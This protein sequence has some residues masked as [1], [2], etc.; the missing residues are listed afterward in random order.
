MTAHSEFMGTCY[1]NQCFAHRRRG[2]HPAGRLAEPAAER[3]VHRPEESPSSVD[4]EPEPQSHLADTQQGVRGPGH[5]GDSDAVR[6]QNQRHR[7]GSV[8]GIGK[9]RVFRPTNLTRYSCY[10]F[11]FVHA[12]AQEIETLESGRK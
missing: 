9:V 2:A 5:A 11:I 12:R 4:T 6:E 3:A 1:F 10:M 7:G 8:P